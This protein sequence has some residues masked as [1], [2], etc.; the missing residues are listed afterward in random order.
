M[1]PARCPLAYSAASRDVEDLGAY[2]PAD[3]FGARWDENLF[4]ILVQR[5]VLASVEDGIVGEVRRSV[6]LVGR[7]E[8]NEFLLD[9]G[10][11]A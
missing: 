4:Q 9:I 1:L 7:D 6:G 11:R 8:T 2:L 5:G 10:C 3:H